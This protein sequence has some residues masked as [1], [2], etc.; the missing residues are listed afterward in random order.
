MAKLSFHPSKLL[1]ID[2][3]LFPPPGSSQNLQICYISGMHD[4]DALI[5]G[6][7]AVGLAVALRLLDAG[8]S[9]A[10]FEAES[11]PGQGISA[12]NSEVAHAGLY[13]PPDFLKT[14]LCIEG[15]DLLENF[16]RQHAVPFKKTGK[17]VVAATEAEIT[18][19]RDLHQRAC[20]NGVKDLRLLDRQELR[21]IEPAV[22]GRAALFSGQTAIFDVHR[23]IAALERRLL[24]AGGHVFYRSPVVRLD[25]AKAAKEVLVGAPNG[26]YT[27]TSRLIINAAGLN[28]ARIAALAGI[29][30]YRIYPVKGEYFRIRNS[31]KGLVRH[32][33]YPAPQTALTGLGIHLTPDLE[34]NLRLG[35]NAIYTENPDYGVDEDHLDDF[36]QGIR[37][38]L[39]LKDTDL[40]PDMAGIRPKIQAPGEGIKDFI[41]RHEDDRG[42]PGLINLVGIESP[43]LTA[44]LAIGAHVRQII[45]A[46][47]LG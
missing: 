20:N 32:L 12:R 34:G 15:R 4:V 19:I 31:C 14:R 43:G 26:P 21:R 38:L 37:R 17:L 25:A 35:P 10:V 1:F 28:S 45:A 18:A 40:H 9:V 3:P 30:D 11:G 47:G 13:Y 39:P 23:Y 46:A 16:C 24:A 2:K 44:S 22:T 29:P 8:L 42:L 7:G 33:I 36:H 41:I 27:V 5:I 6:A